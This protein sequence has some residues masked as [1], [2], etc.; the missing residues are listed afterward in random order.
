MEKVTTA[1]SDQK[2]IRNIMVFLQSHGLGTIHP[3]AQELYWV[4]L[5]APAALYISLSEIFRQAAFSR[6]IVNAH[7]INHDEMP[8]NQMGAG[9]RDLQETYSAHYRAY[10]GTIRFRLTGRIAAEKGRIIP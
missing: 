5:S 8:L 4:I 7:R 6:I 3:L 2:V 1:W 10:T 9:R